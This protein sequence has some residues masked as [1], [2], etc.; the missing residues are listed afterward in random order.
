MYSDKIAPLRPAEVLVKQGTGIA[1]W[2]KANRRQFGL[3][4]NQK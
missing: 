4:E 1:E 3:S 2:P